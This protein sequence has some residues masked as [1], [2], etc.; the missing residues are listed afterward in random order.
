MTGPEP[1]SLPL[2]EPRPGDLCPVCGLPDPDHDWDVHDAAPPP[3]TALE[4]RTAAL[5]NM[6]KRSSTRGGYGVRVVA[7]HTTEGIM[8][9]ADLRAWSS[10][11]G[12]SHA[13]ADET[14]ALL[15]PA[16][17]FVPYHL[18]A[19]TL[20]S[21]NPWSDNLEMCGFARW[22]RAEWLARPKLLD[23]VARWLAD[24]HLARGVPLNK[25]TVAQYRAGASGVIDH[26]DHTV[27]YTDGTHWDVG[28]SFP[29]D[30]VLPAARAYAAGK[31]PAGGFLMALSDAQQQEVYD[32]LK[33]LSIAVDWWVVRDDRG[34]NSKGET[35]KRA[36]GAHVEAAATR[37][38]VS[39]VLA[40]VSKGADI[41]EAGLARELAPA[42]APLVVSAVT[43]QLEGVGGLTGAQLTSA[44][45]AGVRNVFGSL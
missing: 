7:L 16:D 36:E 3:A 23:A 20:R 11:T 28:K 30:I 17:G 13:S 31:T 37:A 22:T 27:G 14:G 1:G 8:R 44:V 9:A 34:P 19:W 41:D 4:L 6:L 18:A 2:G 26:N 10:W 43:K 42:L 21:G 12:S 35:S 40:I 38:M 33:G 24:R 45:E 29:Y 25:I 39:Q 5:P 32:R 15:T